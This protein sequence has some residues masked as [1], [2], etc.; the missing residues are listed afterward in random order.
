M[1]SQHVVSGKSAPGRRSRI[2]WASLDRVRRGWCTCALWRTRR[3]ARPPMPVLG[4]RARSRLAL[5]QLAAQLGVSVQTL[6]DLRSQGRR[7]RGFRV[8]R[9]LRFRVSEIAAW[10]N[11]MEATTL[12]DTSPDSARWAK[13]PSRHLR[14]GRFPKIA[15]PAGPFSG[16]ETARVACAQKHLDLADASRGFPFQGAP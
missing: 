16:V 2:V 7:P 9:E 11:Q 15:W 10:L 14:P 3:S 5:S 8:G 6:Y 12:S 1:A 4:G 13:S